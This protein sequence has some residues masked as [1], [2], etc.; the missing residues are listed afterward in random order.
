MALPRITDDER[1]R[2][3]GVRQALSAAHRLDDVTRVTEAM[4][5]LHATEAATVHLAV[6]ARTT[7]TSP[8][9]VDR[10]LYDDRT[11]VKQLAMR[12]TLFV[13]PCDLLP[14]AHRWVDRILRSAPLALRLT[15]LALRVP[16]EAHPVF[17]NVAQAVLFE[18]GEK[19]ERMTGFLEKR[20]PR[21]P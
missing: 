5:V 21:S 17:D 10:A 12:R 2:R 14:A 8:A 7:G 16:R 18:T 20:S 9:D 6:H 11:L 4:T 1:R 13:M 19:Q 15:K 3:I